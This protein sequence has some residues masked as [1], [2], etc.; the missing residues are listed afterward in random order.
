[1]REHEIGKTLLEE[2]TNMKLVE[3][4]GDTIHFHTPPNPKMLSCVSKSADV[5]KA[6]SDLNREWQWTLRALLL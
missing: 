4:I 1:M 2:M 3:I 6:V 5:A